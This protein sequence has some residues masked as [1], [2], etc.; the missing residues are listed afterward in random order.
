MS[1]LVD[2]FGHEYKYTPQQFFNLPI[3][4]TFL[5]IDRIKARYPKAKGKG[6]K[7]IPTMSLDAF[8]KMLKGK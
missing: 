5:L 2:L 3:T 6:S 8:G 4:G 1:L 7:Q